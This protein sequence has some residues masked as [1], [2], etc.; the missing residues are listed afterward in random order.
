MKSIKIRN[1]PFVEHIL[2]IIPDKIYIRLQFRKNLGRW[3]NLSHPTTFNEKIQWLKLYDRNPLYCTLVDKYA[4]KQYISDK[5][6]SEYVIP[7][8]AVWK[9]VD[10]INLDQLPNQFVL[11]WNHDSGSIVICRDKSSL[12]LDKAKR[13]LSLGQRRNG[14]WYGR[15]WPYKNVKPLLIAEKF[16]NEN[17]NEPNDYKFF[18]FNGKVNFFKVDFNR[19]TYHQA[20][21]YDTDLKLLPFGEVSFPRDPNH[22]TYIPPNIKDMIRIAEQLSEDLPFVR[23][24]LYCISGQIYFGEMTFYPTSGYGRLAPS[25]WDK[26]LGDMIHLEQCSAD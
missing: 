9:S 25:I 8:L 15:E 4:V 26:K 13:R 19:F 23:V 1:H 18:C 12:D 24:D 17:G 16:L 3:P 7:T 11:K 22:N 14:Y 20:N 2:R 21:Y 10:D 6:G 5:I